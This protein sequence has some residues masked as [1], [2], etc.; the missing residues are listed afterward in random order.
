MTITVTQEDIDNGDLGEAFCCP[1][2]RAA[3]RVLNTD[4]G[5]TSSYL[6]ISEE[7]GWR[8]V[9][10]PQEVT[11]FVRAFDRNQEVRPFD[12]ELPYEVKQ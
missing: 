5:V 11:A 9:R 4:V 12:F 2:A 3:Q 6:T 10:A 7:F 1:I 8:D